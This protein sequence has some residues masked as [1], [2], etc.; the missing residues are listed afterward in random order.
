MNN[1]A[2]GTLVC[3]PWAREMK[4]LSSSVLCFRRL[5]L[6]FFIGFFLKLFII[7]GLAVDRHEVSY[8]S[9]SLA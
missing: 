5:F 9:L 6:R 2:E 7:L 1:A 8:R 3:V 4:F